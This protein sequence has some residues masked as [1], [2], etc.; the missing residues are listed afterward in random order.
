MRGQDSS[1]VVWIIVEAFRP[2]FGGGFRSAS[3]AELKTQLAAYDGYPLYLFDGPQYVSDWW[4]NG[5]ANAHRLNG[6]ET[7]RNCRTLNSAKFLA[8]RLNAEI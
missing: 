8:P 7:S 4:S 6:T 3:A 5:C 2:S 1:G